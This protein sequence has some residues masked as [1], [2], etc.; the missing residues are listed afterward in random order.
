MKRIVILIIQNVLSE[1]DFA[2]KLEML[3]NLCDLYRKKKDLAT[4]Q[5]FVI[6]SKELSSLF[7]IC[8]AS[9]PY[10]TTETIFE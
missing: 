8:G 6:V 10:Y 7:K 3:G 1:N 9:R 2:S 4:L 5:S